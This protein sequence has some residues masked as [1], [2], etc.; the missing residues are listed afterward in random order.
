MVLD[1]LNNNQPLADFSGVIAL[2]VIAPDKTEIIL[3]NFLPTGQPGEVRLVTS[4]EKVG[5]YKGMV[6]YNE[7]KVQAQGY[8]EINIA[9]R[10]KLFGIF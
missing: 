5:S 1:P 4:F 7:H 6:L 3:E 9:E 8:A 2:Q 10:K